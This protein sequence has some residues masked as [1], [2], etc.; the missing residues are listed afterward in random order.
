MMSRCKITPKKDLMLLIHQQI[1]FVWKR[2]Q[3]LKTSNNKRRKNETKV[4]PKVIM[5]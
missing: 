2:M 1:M 5:L 4:K 3:T